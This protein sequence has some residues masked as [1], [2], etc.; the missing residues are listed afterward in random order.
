MRPSM[1]PKKIVA[2]HESPE[3]PP[4]Q[5]SYTIRYNLS[6]S[7]ILIPAQPPTTNARHIRPKPSTSWH[8]KLLMRRARHN[9][10]TPKAKRK[11]HLNL[12]F[13]PNFNNPFLDILLS[14]QDGQVQRKTSFSCPVSST[15]SRNSSS[16]Q[17]ENIISNM[18]AESILEPSVDEKTSTSE[19]YIDFTKQWIE[20]TY[21]SWFGENKTSY[22]V[23]GV[24]AM[25]LPHYLHQ[26]TQC[27]RCI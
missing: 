4:S 3:A 13:S 14:N 12:L 20:G 23:K 24:K 18:N 5:L 16:R 26:L 11:H 22:S 15:S 8:L 17:L 19:G 9:L 10:K 1:P 2:L 25:L 27:T 7:H 6:P 21:L